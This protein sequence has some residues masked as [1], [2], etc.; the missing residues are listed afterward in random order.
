[1][2]SGIE[3]Y[4]DYEQI[5]MTCQPVESTKV[6]MAGVEVARY[7]QGGRPIETTFTR[8][9]DGA[10][11][12]QI[13]GEAN[14]W[15]TK[16]REPYLEGFAGKADF[17][18]WGMAVLEELMTKSTCHPDVIKE[19]RDL[20]DSVAAVTD[21]LGMFFAPH[22][23]WGITDFFLSRKELIAKGEAKRGTT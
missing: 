8:L 20:D 4:F 2:V 13:T 12:H 19:P 23:S 6:S 1:M 18:D 14:T 22:S 15:P 7:W 11:L 16:P 10:C 21:C 9:S 3:K 5:A 17:V